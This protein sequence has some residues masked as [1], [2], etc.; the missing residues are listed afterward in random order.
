MSDRKPNSGH[1]RRGHDP[2]RH[3]LTTEER[4]KGYRSAVAGASPGLV[5]W[6]RSR[7][8]CT[9]RPETVERYKAEWL[10]QRADAA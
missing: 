2:R 3:Q 7:V 1:F 9:A 5:K 4:Q 8:A 10:R 6:L